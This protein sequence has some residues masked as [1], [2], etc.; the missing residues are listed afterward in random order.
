MGYTPD[1]SELASFQ[2]YQWVWYWDPTDMQ[3]QKLGRR[4]GVANTSGS[5]Y[6][7]F[8]INTNTKDISNSTATHLTDEECVTIYEHQKAYVYDE[9]LDCENS[10]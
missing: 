1:I 4:Y 3:R 2:W 7:Y 9:I 8:I 10:Y 6:T 5:G